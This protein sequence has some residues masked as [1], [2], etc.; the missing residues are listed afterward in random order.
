MI[1]T[2]LMAPQ[3]AQ[4]GFVRTLLDIELGAAFT[5]VPDKW[6]NE[7][8]QPHEPCDLASVCN[9]AAFLFCMTSRGRKSADWMI[10]HNLGQLRGWLREW[11]KGQR[12]RGRNSF[13]EFDLGFDEVEHHV[14]ISVVDGAHAAGAWH[15]LSPSDYATK[16]RSTSAAVTLPANVIIYVLGHSGSMHTILDVAL[17]LRDAGRMVPERELLQHVQW[18]HRT[19]TR[20]AIEDCE[21]HSTSPDRI[22]ARDMLRGILSNPITVA[23][24]LAD[25]L[26]VLQRGDDALIVLDLD[27]EGPEMAACQVLGPGGLLE[28]LNDLRW[29][30]IL[31]IVGLIT[32]FW[33]Q[34]DGPK[35]SRMV[36]F[37]LF[38]MQAASGAYVLVGGQPASATE[39]D[40]FDGWADDFYTH[41]EATTRG[42]IGFYYFM[43]RDT[44]PLG[45]MAT[46]AR[47]G[48][49]SLA[50]RLSAIR[51]STRS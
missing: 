39:P 12:L 48:Q 46:A 49:S 23:T 32:K 31:Q 34:F 11:S 35:V 6:R 42:C 19:A 25:G 10:K 5:F 30:E 40:Y 13:R 36:A 15:V 20:A 21:G 4:E 38:D 37:T 3:S 2:R 8:G 47:S 28:L 44:V 18:M 26:N 33:A 17:W 22:S 24:S 43:R 7:G 29:N 16:A 41:A 27:Q 51:R 14:L 45:P 9:G 50:K 1:N